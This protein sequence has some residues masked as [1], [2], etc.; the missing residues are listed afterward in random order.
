[1]IL[2]FASLSSIALIF[3]NISAATVLSEV[4]R[5]LRTALRAVFA[6]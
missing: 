4:E 3:G 2:R 5:N 6:K 1:M